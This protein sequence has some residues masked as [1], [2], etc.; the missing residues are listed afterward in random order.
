MYRKNIFYSWLGCI[1]TFSC[2][3]NDYVENVT[4]PKLLTRLLD[5]QTRAVVPEC[6]IS[7]PAHRL[8][9]GPMPARADGCTRNTQSSLHG[10]LLQIAVTKW[11]ILCFSSFQIIFSYFQSLC[12]H[13][14]LLL[15][16]DESSVVWLN[17][18]KPNIRCFILYSVGFQCCHFYN[19]KSI[20]VI[21][22]HTLV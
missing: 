14:L 7:P 15:T 20:W 4:S 8:L 9:A 21:K 11:Y 16:D 19:M 3:R 13:N 18:C 12:F 1:W 6:S 5:V 2:H 17:P 22:E 10:N